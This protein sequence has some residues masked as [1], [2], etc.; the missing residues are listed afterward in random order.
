M[1]MNKMFYDIEKFKQKNREMSKFHEFFELSY[2]PLPQYV[3][4]YFT[5][6]R[7]FSLM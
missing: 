3:Q 5:I 1:T 6:F 7:C 4:V 2:L